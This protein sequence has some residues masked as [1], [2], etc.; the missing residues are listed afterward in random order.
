MGGQGDFVGAQS[1]H[2]EI[3]HLDHSIDAHK[4]LEYVHEIHTFRH[5]LHQHNHRVPEYVER[6]DQHQQGEKKR[7]YRV[8]D[9]P[10][11]L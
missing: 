2:P 8:H 9:F 5:T 10:F 4:R 3:V 6:G 1:P 7:T 11:G